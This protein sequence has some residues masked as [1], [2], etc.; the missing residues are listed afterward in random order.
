M[1]EVEE[2]RN[3]LRWAMP[4]VELALEDCRQMRLRLGHDDIGAGTDHIGLWPFEVA[5]RDRARALVQ[6][7]DMQTTDNP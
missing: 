5:A 4:L 3:A 2:L 6:K 1:S 7:P